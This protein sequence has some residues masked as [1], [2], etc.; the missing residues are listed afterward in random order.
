[1][2]KNLSPTLSKTVHLL[3]EILGLVIKEQEGF[4]LFNKVE[5]IRILSKKSRSNKNTEEVNQVFNKLKANIIGLNPKES[6]VIA[7]SF[8]QFLNFSN[9]AESLFS[10]QKIHSSKVRKAQ[11]T[12]EF[13]ILED[14]IANLLK[15]KSI[16]KNK[17]Y[18][19]AKQLKIEL[20]LTAHP[21]EV[22]RRTL[23][24]KYAHVN[25]ILVRFNNT[26]IFNIL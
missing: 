11:G 4:S 26:R 6:L 18:Q 1:M 25:D 7:R 16:S 9:L 17:F 20:V 12:N 21:T 14:A 24:Q 8:S 23:I 13:I 22:K 15:K 3:G 5:K 19:L 10:V 2:R